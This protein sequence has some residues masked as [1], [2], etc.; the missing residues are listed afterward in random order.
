MHDLE[1]L[2][3]GSKKWAD[4]IKADDPTYFS[5]L[6]QQKN[7]KYLWIGCSDNRIMENRII[8]IDPGEVFVH[9][10]IAN[11][12]GHS[13]LNCLS[14]IHY[15]VEVLKVQHIILC[16]H[17]DCGGI[18]AALAD[19]ENGLIENWLLPIKEIIQLNKKKI[20]A[21]NHAKSID[22]LCELNVKEQ[23]SNIC[24]TSIVRRAW[25][26]NKKLSVHGW[27]YRVENGELKNIT[28]CD[29]NN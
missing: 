24:N 29:G 18:K 14:V 16:G 17:Y 1:F 26:S 22:L 28:S 9:R 21:L 20:D 25:K 13:D 23:V 2:L 5:R 4:E 27:I 6:S 15:A 11:I 3:D 19:E 12:V 7:P 8:K 10:N